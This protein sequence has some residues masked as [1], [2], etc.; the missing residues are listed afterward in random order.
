MIDAYQQLIKDVLSGHGR[1][2]DLVLLMGVHCGTRMHALQVAR[3]P[4]WSAPA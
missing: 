1:R 4:G 2:A 3:L